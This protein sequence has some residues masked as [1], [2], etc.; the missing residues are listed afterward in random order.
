MQLWTAA[1][2][3]EKDADNDVSKELEDFLED[4]DENGARL[5]AFCHKI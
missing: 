1:L 5:D 2:Y 3:V 4:S